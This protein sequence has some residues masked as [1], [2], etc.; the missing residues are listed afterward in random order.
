MVTLDDVTIFFN[1][2]GDSGDCPCF[3]IVDS[4]VEHGERVFDFLDYGE[5]TKE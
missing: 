4:F 2:F 5:Y 3:F 1:V